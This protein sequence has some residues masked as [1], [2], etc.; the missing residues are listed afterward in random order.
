MARPKERSGRYER[1]TLEIRSDLLEWLDTN[2][3]SRR[4]TIEQLLEQAKVN[5]QEEQAMQ[6]QE[7]KEF[8]ASIK[9]TL[10]AFIA[11]P[12]F[13]AGCTS[14]TKASWG[15]SGYSVELFTDGTWRVLWDHQIGN[16][17][18]SA[19]V[20]LSLPTIND[21][22]YQQLVNGSVDDDEDDEDS[23]YGN[24]AMSEEEF[25]S[26]GFQNEFDDL[27]KELRDHLSDDFAMRYSN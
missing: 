20:I 5:E 8:K 1:I 18:E 10:N 24:G 15:G 13:E 25:F 4:A 17:Y 3:Q 6:A 16:K 27:A 26:L 14:A 11:S 7:L 21:D 22:E 23:G 9:K 2:T 19:G 12:D